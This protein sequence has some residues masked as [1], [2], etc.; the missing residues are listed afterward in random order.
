MSLNTTPLAEQVYSRFDKAETNAFLWR[1]RWYGYQN[2]KQV[3][4]IPLRQRIRAF[5]RGDLLCIKPH[6]CKAS[7]DPGRNST[8]GGLLKM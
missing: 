5:E 3:N 4:L 7:Q 6:L 1:S 2:K 8:R